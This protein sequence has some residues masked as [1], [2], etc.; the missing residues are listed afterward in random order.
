MADPFDTLGVHPA[1]D[2]DLK[3]LEQ[4]Y[5]DLSRVLHPDRHVGGPASER[6]MALGR[7]VEVNEAWRILRDPLAR[8]EALLGRGAVVPGARATADPGFLME[9]MEQREE[10]SEARRSGDH[11]RVLRLAGEITA[12]RD[13][14]MAKLSTHFREVGVAS[15]PSTASEGVARS[16]LGELR[17]YQRFLDEVSAIDDERSET[18]P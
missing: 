17:Y 5:R 3:E 16:L 12:K 14:A 1:F 8:A 18:S 10:L 4:R 7:A 2:L 9:M 15:E 11:A 13:A 6:R